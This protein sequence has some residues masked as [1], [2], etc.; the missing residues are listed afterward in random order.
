MSGCPSFQ[1]EL[2]SGGSGA[3]E[4]SPAGA[5]A[6]TQLLS[7]SISASVRLGSSTNS[8]CSGL[9]NQGGIVRS[10]VTLRIDFAQGR[11]SS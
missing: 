11:V 7:V 1:S 3:S 6:A 9:A 4:R 2:K 5:P 10:V 8:P